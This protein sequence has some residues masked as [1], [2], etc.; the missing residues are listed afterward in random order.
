ME[1]NR[2]F[3]EKENKVILE[4]L[5]KQIKYSEQKAEELRAQIKLYPEDRYS[6]QDLQN[7]LYLRNVLLAMKRRIEFKN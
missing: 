6:K 2:I 1:K 7:D 4:Y 5:D 3:T